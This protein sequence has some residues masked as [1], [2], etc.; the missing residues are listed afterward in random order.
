MCI[1]TGPEVRDMAQQADRFQA[2]MEEARA[3][4][5]A[6]DWP[7]YAYDSL[8]LFSIL[9]GVLTGERRYLTELIGDRPVLD[10]GC[11]DGALSFFFES[12]GFHVTAI[13][14][15]ATNCNRMEGVRAIRDV[16]GSSV[17]VVEADLDRGGFEAPR[18]EYGLALMLGLLYHLRNPFHV[19]EQI[20][21][22]ARYCLLSTRVARLTPDRAVRMERLPVAY[23]VDS[24]EL[25]ADVT[26]YW[27][28][29][30]AGL[31]RLIRR[32]GWTI[33]DIGNVGNTSDSDPVREDADERC[34]CLLRR[35]DVG[36]ES[37]GD[38]IEA[39][40]A[41]G[42]YGRGTGEG[43]WRWTARAFGLNV[44]GSASRD[45][46]RL[47]L[48]LYV[49][50]VLVETAGAVTL[51]L[52]AAGEVLSRRTFSKPGQHVFEARLPAALTAG[53]GLLEFELDRWLPPSERD[54]RELGVVVS[55]I[56][57]D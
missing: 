54:A 45:R 3:R 2:V 1:H 18:P 23:L 47:R 32:A 10:A 46:G 26:N 41:H 43:Q 31:E 30:Q 40:L 6:R 37:G 49:P 48:G 38:G 34:Y 33:V 4:V 21:R 7:W 5:G 8:G 28:F 57:V 53:G 22:H 50:P 51:T 29:S 39:A 9:D 12:L 11:G 52:S 25:N 15:P 36:P 27:I 20:G 56:L 24:D 13:D 17:D 42:W 16:L 19:L 35:A 14:N 44:R 55:E